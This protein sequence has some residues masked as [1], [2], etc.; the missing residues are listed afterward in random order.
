MQAMALAALR[1]LAAAA[2]R[3]AADIVLKTP[4]LVGENV[5]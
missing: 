5:K 3:R 1:P 2:P 4:L